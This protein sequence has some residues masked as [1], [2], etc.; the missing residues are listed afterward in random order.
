[1]PRGFV[2]VQDDLFWTRR[3][4]REEFHQVQTFRDLEVQ[5]SRA[6]VA[7]AVTKARSVST[8]LHRRVDKGV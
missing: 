5:E 1:M 8:L 2:N 4:R 7:Q 3:I 6:R